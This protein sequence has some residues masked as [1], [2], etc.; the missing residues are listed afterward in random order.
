MEGLFA[1]LWQEEGQSLTEYA[2]L[3]ILVSLMTLSTMKDFA[4]TVNNIYSRTESEIAGSQISGQ[5]KSGDQSRYSSHLKRSSSNIQWDW[6][7]GSHTKI[8]NGIQ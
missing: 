7:H 4:S 6:H 8:K 5:T 2:L 3:L 1:K